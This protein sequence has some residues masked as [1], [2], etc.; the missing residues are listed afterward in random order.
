MGGSKGGAL[1]S[2]TVSEANTAAAAARTG[3]HG[4]KSVHR[5]NLCVHD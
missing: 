4:V 5:G 2:S 3:Y 1:R